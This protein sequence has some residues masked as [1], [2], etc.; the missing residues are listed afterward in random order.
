MSKAPENKRPVITVEAVPGHPEL[1]RVGCP[2]PEAIAKLPYA[3]IGQLFTDA[4][5]AFSEREK[6][7]G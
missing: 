4:L 6:A 2:D 7:H 5:N 3:E 1:V